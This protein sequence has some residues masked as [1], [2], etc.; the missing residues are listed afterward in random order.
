VSNDITIGIALGAH[1][2]IKEQTSDIHR[3]TSSQPMNIDT[4]SG[5]PKGCL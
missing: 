4:D 1:L 2:V 3:P 5:T